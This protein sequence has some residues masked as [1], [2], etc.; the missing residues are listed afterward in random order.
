MKTSILPLAS[1]LLAAS[2]LVPQSDAQTT[3]VVDVNGGPGSDFLEIQPAL[4]VA[5]PFDVIEVR[6]G[7]YA[8]FAA[9][10]AARI[11]SLGHVVLSS[12]ATITGVDE[13]DWMVVAGFHTRSMEVRDCE[14][15][16]LIEDLKLRGVSGRLTIDRCAD[17]RL[18]AIDHSTQNSFSALEINSSR[19]QVTDSLLGGYTK[20]NN[21]VQGRHA[22]ELTGGSFFHALNCDIRGE[23]GGDNDDVIGAIPPAG[24]DCIHSR[25]ES[26]A[27]VVRCALSPGIGGTNDGYPWL[28][29]YGR[30]GYYLDASGGQHSFWQTTYYTNSLSGGA[31]L[32][33]SIP[34]PSLQQGAGA[35]TAGS[36]VQLAVR[37]EPGSSGRLLFGRRPL[38]VAQPNTSLERLVDIG[39]LASLGSMSPT[40]VQTLTF[41][42]PAA[43]PRGTVVFLQTSATV[44]GG[45]TDMSNSVALIVR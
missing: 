23:E 38:V 16:V 5:G 13:G 27:R 35:L 21:Y 26:E 17:V 25:N 22:V 15:T 10:R 29:T 39:R 45:A 30:N 8:P 33:N 36:S 40:G 31:T 20:A 3:Y 7:G 42:I 6:P 34:L 28:P 9:T 1:L 14:G 43:W 32:E 2:A 24:G 19:V 18:R 11:I 41:P 4:D 37:S 44:A 12:T